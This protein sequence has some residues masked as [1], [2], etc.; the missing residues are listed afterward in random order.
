MRARHLRA[1]VAA[2]AAAVVAA[3]AGV[4]DT[5]SA[6][7]VAALPAH[8]FAPYFETWTTDGITTYDVSRLDFDV[9]GRSLTRTDG[10]DRRNKATKIVEDWAASQGRPL[11][12]SY[13][14]PT[15]ANGLESSGVAVL[16]NA[17]ANGTRVDVVN[18]MTFDY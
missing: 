3:T 12:I 4:A 6:T 13:T 8:V 14:L 9:E 2:C 7:T 5:R 18:I 17:I 15:S 1:C 11:Q 10:I 16:Q